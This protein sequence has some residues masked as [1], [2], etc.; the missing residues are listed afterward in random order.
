MKGTAAALM[1]ILFFG[2]TDNGGASRDLPAIDVYKSP[3]C[4]C[5]SKW[6][7]HLREY[8]FTVTTT[9]TDKV[10]EFKDKHAVPADLRSC[11]TALVAGYVVEGHVPAADIE[12]LL[13]ERRATA[14]IAVPGMPAG[15][16]G[17]EV[18]G[19][20][21]RPYQVMAFDKGEQTG[22]FATHGR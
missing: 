21:P 10:E 8:G 15:S 22:V 3:T 19:V 1:A 18:P 14:G 4:G 13:K 6:V 20:K 7:T 2:C 17:M 12:R 16:P 9:D 5:C 11:H